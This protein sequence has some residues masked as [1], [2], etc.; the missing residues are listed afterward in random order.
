MSFSLLRVPK[1]AALTAMRGLVVGTSCTLVFIT[2]DRRRRI[3]K[4]RCAIRNADRIRSVKKYHATRL[5]RHAESSGASSSLEDE[6]APGAVDAEGT[7]LREDE[8]DEQDGPSRRTELAQALPSQSAAVESLDNVV[9]ASTVKIVRRRDSYHNWRGTSE[10]PSQIEPGS[11]A[12][13]EAPPAAARIEK[14]PGPSARE[15]RFNLGNLGYQKLSPALFRQSVPIKQTVKKWE[16]PNFSPAETRRIID[17]YENV[18]RAAAS[19]S[20][21]PSL[22]RAINALRDSIRSRDVEAEGKE[23]LVSTA[24]MLCS[25]S[26]RAENMELAAR[27]LY[28]LVALGPLAEADYYASNPDPVINHAISIAEMEIEKLKAEEGQLRND[29]LVSARRKLAWAV[30]LLMPRLVEGTLS[31]PRLPAWLSLAERSMNLAFDL[32][33]M[34]KEAANL[35]WRIQHY[36]GDPLGEVARHY[37]ERLKSQG[38]PQSIVNGFNL[39]R[40]K[41]VHLQPDTWYAVGDLAADAV[42]DA[43]GQDPAKLLRHMIEFCPPA[44]DPSA[45][46]LRTTWVTKILYCQ[47][48]RVGNFDD[49]LALFRQFEQLG[50]FSKVVYADGVYRVMLQIAVEAG[51]WTQ[52]DEFLKTLQEIKPSSAKEARILGLVALAKAKMGDWSGVWTE[53]ENMEIKDRMEDMFSPILHEFI[54]THTTRETEDFLKT[55][56]QDLEVPIHPYMVTMIA[57]K[58]GDIR[59]VHSFT[60]WL[61][62]CSDKGFEIDAAFS[63]AIVTNCKKR[64]DFSFD[65]LRLIYRTLRDLSPNFVDHVTENEMILTGLAT[66]RRAKPTFVKRQ[67]ASVGAKFQRRH[68]TGDISDTRV[69]IRQ[70]F[71]TRNY[72]AVLDMYRTACKQGV[73]LDDGHLR[74]AVKACMK[75]G[76]RLRRALVLIREGKARGLDVS[77]AIT[78]IFLLEIHQIFTRDTEDKDELLREVQNLV[79]SFEEHELSLGYAALLRTAHLLLRARHVQGALTFGL[80]AL[81]RKG[82]PY[83]EDIAAFQLFILAYAFK[84][85][86]QGMR[87]TI[88][89][90]VH[91]QFYHKGSVYRALKDARNLLQKHIQSSDVKEALWVVEQGIDRVRIR[92]DELVG[93]RQEVERYVMEIMKRAAL[94]AEQQPTSEEALR[95]RDEAVRQLEE[96]ARRVEEERQRKETQRSEEMAARWVAAD[97][98]MRRNTEEAAM[99]EKILE[100]NSHQIVGDF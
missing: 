23:I 48:Q 46:P 96:T 56:I 1:K 66:H 22:E 67:I 49:T 59:D 29:K 15:I 33:G 77:S 25:Q 50:G 35:F 86:V 71:V 84:A 19:S 21:S 54:K 91:V 26:Q 73:S 9:N 43:P 5:I 58:Y 14:S 65:D 28:C 60:D 17:A 75:L 11:E 64:W 76:G 63:N 82:V 70:A 3:D 74:L 32:G 12:R 83:P 99:M 2:E 68:L 100:E 7:R 78:P 39:L 27:A 10:P 62:Y 44:H 79:A 13:E 53:F 8:R 31:A 30:S 94:E 92:R 20:D 88:A 4:A 42:E 80:S 69:H 85:D 55:Y 61:L 98:Q 95:R 45:M 18:Q 97:E 40:R 90:A 93:E 57:N 6:S 81:E 89:S 36:Q 52:A 87:W 41:W 51:Q 37:F 34:T 16:N 72:R 47:W 24:T 38:G